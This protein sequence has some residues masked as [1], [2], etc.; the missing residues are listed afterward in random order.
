MARSV[1]QI[2]ASIV[3]TVKANFLAVGITID[4]VNW[5]KR[6]MIRL[7][8]YSFAICSAYVEQLM[9][10]LQLSLETTASKTPAASQLWIQAKMFLFQYSESNPQIV[11]LINL[12][13]Q[14]LVV[15]PSL[16]IITAC[17]ISSDV[18]N[19]V[20]VKVAKT[21]TGSLAALSSDELIAAQS[22]I[23]T[24]GAGGINYKVKSQATDRIMIDAD[25]YYTGQYSSLS[26]W[27]IDSLVSFLQNLSLTNFDGSI[28]VTDI[29]SAIRK[30]T[31][32]NDVVLNNV[33]VR[34]SGS[35]YDDGIYIVANKTTILR[36][37]K[38]VAGYC[39]QE[40]TTGHTFSSTLHFIAE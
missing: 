11:Q 5:S 35:S 21:V 29:E 32:I 7:F 38:T 6:N 3:S 12:V 34:D 4:T 14:Y 36:Q 27:V 16:R 22:Y 9:D 28:K 23:E 13:P 2:N 17:A 31:G 20:V 8:C 33:R 1:D 19:E 30:V 10:S 39:D 15:D 40:N 37:W 24:I 18:S 26:Q 25:I